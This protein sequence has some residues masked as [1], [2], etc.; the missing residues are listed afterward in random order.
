MKGPFLA[1]A[2][3]ILGFALVHAYAPE[4]AREEMRWRDGQV[5]MLPLAG[6]GTLIPIYQPGGYESVCVEW[7]P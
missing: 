1:I 5:L 6:D 4:C 7:K 2:A 3:A